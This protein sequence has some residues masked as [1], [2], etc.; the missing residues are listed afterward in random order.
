M[1]LLHNLLTQIECLLTQ[2]EYFLVFWESEITSTYVIN[3]AVPNYIN[4]GLLYS[5]TLWLHYFKI[6][7]QCNLAT[8]AF[9]T[10]GQLKS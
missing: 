4:V 10:I 3:Y 9:T 6:C 8:L 5:N 2:F 1:T 7:L